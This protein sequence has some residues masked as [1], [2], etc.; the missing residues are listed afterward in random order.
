MVDASTRFLPLAFD[1]NHPVQDLNSGSKLLVSTKT[2][3]PTKAN[4]I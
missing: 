3:E 2:P 4:L 1:S